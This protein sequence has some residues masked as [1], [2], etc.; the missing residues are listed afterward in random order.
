MCSMDE[1]LRL[2]YDHIASDVIY[3]ESHKRA[4]Y[5]EAMLG[6]EMEENKLRRGCTPEQWRQRNRCCDH[7]V[8]AQSEVSEIFF[9]QGVAVGKYLSK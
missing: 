8:A 6:C 1:Y 4:A 2:I 7:C 3:G 5:R 9:E